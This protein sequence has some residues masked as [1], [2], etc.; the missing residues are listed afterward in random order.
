MTPDPRPPRSPR[1][2]LNQ[3]EA[4]DLPISDLLD[5]FRRCDEFVALLRL[6]RSTGGKYGRVERM[7]TE[8]AQLEQEMERLRT[9][10]RGGADGKA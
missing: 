1:L 10:A 3:R 7:L 6:A 2:G 9:K 5:L 4:L 8:A